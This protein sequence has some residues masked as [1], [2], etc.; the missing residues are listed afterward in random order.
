M[1]L[2]TKVFFVIIIVYKVSKASKMAGGD[3]K[4]T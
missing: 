4:N 2:V 3:T 1:T